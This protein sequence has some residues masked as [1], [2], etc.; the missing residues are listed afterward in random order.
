[1]G[2]AARIA[3]IGGGPAG[4]MAAECARAEGAEVHLYDHKSS[5]GRKVLIAGKGGLN[6]THSE[7]RPQFDQRYRERTTEVGQWLD[8]FDGDAFREWVHAFGIATVVGSSGRVFP[9]DL[10]AAPLLRAWVRRLKADGV[11]FHVDAR[12][13][14][15]DANGACLFRTKDASLVD[16]FDAVVLALGGGSWPELGSDGQWTHYFDNTAVKVRPLLPANCGFECA[17]STHF[18][19]RFAGH[20]LKRVRALCL[21]CNDPAAARIGEC[22]ISTYGLEGSLIYAL[23]ASLRDQ[24]LATGHATL[25]LDLQPD[26]DRATL[27]HRLLQPRGG[28]SLGEHLRRKGGL[29]AVQVALVFEQ[30][31]KG[32]H[33]ADACAQ[34][35]K[36]CQIILRAARPIEEAI[37]SAGGVAFDSLTDDL[38]LAARPG[39]FCAGE[40]IDWEAP[41]GGYLLTACMASGKLAG[42][43]A[44]RW[45]KQ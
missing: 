10:K 18:T 19:S 12:W 28:R 42:Q 40:M 39:V 22:V 3:I 24:I 15:F 41:T 9:E 44:A 5:V 2:H 26:V 17:W 25:E 16:S 45:A 31:G 8:G 35:V 20:A 32:D 38:M 4:L 14:G 1:M 7:P 23:S 29:N 13:L 33:S 6:L 30:L 37:S 11:H 34:A 27:I 43:A 36:H 21:E